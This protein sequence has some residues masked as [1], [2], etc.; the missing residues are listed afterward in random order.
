MIDNEL[1]L[2]C[3]NDIPFPEAQL[4]IHQPQIKEIALIG[5]H[6]FF[7]ALQILCLNKSMVENLTSDQNIFQIIMTVIKEKEAADKKEAVEQLFTLIFPNYKTT[8]LPNSIILS[9]KEQPSAID[10][11]NFEV[12]QGLLKI[13][14]CM[15]N[16]PMDQTTFDPADAKA[17]E[18]AQK[19]MRGREIVAAQKNSEN[20][21][22]ILGRY[23]S[24][25]AIGLNSNLQNYATLT[26]YQLYDQFERFGLYTAWDL[27]IKSR[28][29]GG[30]PEHEP[31][32]WMKSIH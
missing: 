26:M 9:G 1:N 24:V 30:K 6:N 7:T 19:L 25:L 20:S 32:N 29:A 22:S 13:I 3:G 5:E 16:G 11:N 17:K 4:I 21:G 12:F 27:D 15:Q 18:I 14:F 8:F 28:L 23:M 2:M 31:E 10:E